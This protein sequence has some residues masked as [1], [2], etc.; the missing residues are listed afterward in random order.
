MTQYKIEPFNK[1]NFKDKYIIKKKGNI[2]FIKLL[3]KDIANWGEILSKI[4][5]RKIIIYSDNLTKNKSISKLYE[6]F[7]LNY[8]VSNFYIENILKNDK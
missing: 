7:K 3:F 1:F 2:Y 5:D 8:K 6:E 4:F